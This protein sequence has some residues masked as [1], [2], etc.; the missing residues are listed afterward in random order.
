MKY[1]IFWH[2]VAITVLLLAWNYYFQPLL[3]PWMPEAVIPLEVRFILLG[4]KSFTLVVATLFPF[5][6]WSE[7]TGKR[8]GIIYA[9]PFERSSLFT[10]RFLLPVIVYMLMLIASY[11]ACYIVS[12][13]ALELGTRDLFRGVPLIFFLL[14]LGYFFAV[15][16]RMPLIGSGVVFLYWFAEYFTRG[17]VSGRFHIFSFGSPLVEEYY[18]LNRATLILFAL[19][20]AVAAFLRFRNNDKI[21]RTE[22]D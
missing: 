20:L 21:A 13:E 12:G 19:I 4:E 9:L 10:T 11:A 18:F 16:S 8:A 14:A 7:L 6:F 17:R 5:A 15:V 1:S 3:F 2:L 22:H